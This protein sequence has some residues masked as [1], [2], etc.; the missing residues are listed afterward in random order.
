[1]GCKIYAGSD[2]LEQMVAD[3]AGNVVVISG[4]N[5]KKTDYIME[6]IKAGFNV[7]SD[8]PMVISPEKYP[9]LEE[10]FALAAEK[11]IL[12]YDVMTE[13]YEITTQLQKKLSQSESIFGK[14]L[15]GSP[16]NPSITKV[17]VHH[18]NKLVAGKL[19]KRPA[20]FFDSSQQGDGLVDVTTHLVDLVQWECYPEVILEKSDIEMIRARH[21]PTVLTQEEFNTVTRMDGFPDYLSPNIKDGKL[22]SFA[23]GE[24]VYKIK[25]VYARVSV[26]WKYKAPEGTG[27]T[28]F[29]EMRGS[30]S[31]ISI[32]QGQEENFK[33]TLYV[34][35]SGEG[36]LEEFENVLSAGINSLPF[37]GLALTKSGPSQW[38]VEIPDKYRIG[39]EAHFGQV[40][41]KY[42]GFLTGDE[43]PEWEIPNM[44][45]KYHT[46][47]SALK[48]AR[49]ND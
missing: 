1:M 20:W 18:F 44:I 23:N 30:N 26:E 14:L 43:I 8:K 19:I 32:R 41:E 16:D 29:S 11:G 39:H 37:D 17:S 13:R 21:W 49:E 42:I 36:S 28:H 5:N 48:M 4:N 10:A 31:T 34:E 33:P 9:L 47:T 2:F 46:T 6:S 12:L 7:L 38:T 3:K 27:D 35:Y 24:M 40:T 45:V 25:D 15:E 22:E